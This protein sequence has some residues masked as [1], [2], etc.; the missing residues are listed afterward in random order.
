MKAEAGTQ[1]LTLPSR[2]PIDRRCRK[3]AR[4]R[5]SRFDSQVRRHSSSLRTSPGA[6]Q[7]SRPDSI[8]KD[9]P[10]ELVFVVD[11][12]AV[13][14]RAI[15]QLLES[16][17]LRAEL[18]GSTQE[19]LEAE[20][21]SV[22]SCLVLDVRLPG[23]SGLD[24]QGDLVKANILIPVVFITGYGDIEMSVQAMKAGAVEFLAKPFRNQ[25]GGR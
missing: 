24:F 12:D 2:K 13:V 22:P 21:P 10:A 19:F 5:K 23:K 17:N 18:F 3:V 6:P 8:L 25:G 15:K 4:A 20:R 14:R 7:P 11:D 16:V 1:R 9:E